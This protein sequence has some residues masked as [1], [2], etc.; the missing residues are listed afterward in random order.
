MNQGLTTGGD[1]RFFSPLQNMRTTS[2]AHPGSYSVQAG[3]KAG[4]C[5]LEYAPPASD[6]VR[7]GGVTPLLPIQ[8]MEAC[9]EK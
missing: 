2:G 4:L 6:K 1:K 9:K 5:E 7:N 8:A 3:G